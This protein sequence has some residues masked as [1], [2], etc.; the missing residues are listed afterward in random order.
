MTEA[1]WLACDDPSRMIEH[2]RERFRPRWLRRLL[3][4]SDERPVHRKLRLFVGYNTLSYYPFGCDNAD[5]EAILDDI[6]RWAEGQPTQRTGAPRVFWMFWAEC[7]SGGNFKIFRTPWEEAERASAAPSP[8]G[9]LI[10]TSEC[11]LLRDIFGNPFR[12]VSVDPSWLTSDVVALASQ[13]YESRDFSAMPILADALQDAGCDNEDILNHCRG[14]D[15]H[16]RG[17]W[18]VDLVLRK[19]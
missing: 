7:C 3:R 2:L 9:S 14:E 6:V 11:A 19:G 17:C 8:P 13:M 16:V 12:P 10:G 5:R 15:V 18:V 4:P 1:E